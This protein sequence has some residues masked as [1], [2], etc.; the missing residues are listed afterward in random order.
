MLELVGNG[1]EETRYVGLLING[2][3]TLWLRSDGSAFD[4]L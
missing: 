4:E 2:D 3:H 1:D